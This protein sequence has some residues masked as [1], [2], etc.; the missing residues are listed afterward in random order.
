MLSLVSKGTCCQ[1]WRPVFD[2][3]IAP[4]GRTELTRASY[5]LTSM[6]VLWHMGTHTQLI[7]IIKN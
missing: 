4:G 3:W 5:P 6:C 7:N 1:T 2:L